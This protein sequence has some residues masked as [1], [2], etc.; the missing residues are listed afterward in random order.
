M[1]DKMVPNT[2]SAALTMDLTK[3]SAPE[4]TSP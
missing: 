1:V 4:R 2:P 3:L